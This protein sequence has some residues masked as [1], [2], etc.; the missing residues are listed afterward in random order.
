MKRAAGFVGMRGKK[1]SNN[2]EAE[3]ADEASEDDDMAQYYFG[4][5]P[6]RAGFV[7]MRG[8]KADEHL[9]DKRAGAA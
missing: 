5:R 8:K 3:A 7:G 6:A 2:F 4:P 1:F 9:Y